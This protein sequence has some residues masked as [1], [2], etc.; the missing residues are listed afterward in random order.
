MVNSWI[1]TILSQVI[2]RK[3]PFSPLDIVED[4]AFLPKLIQLLLIDNELLF[5]HRCS[6]PPNSLLTILIYQ[7]LDLAFQIPTQSSSCPSLSVDLMSQDA[8]RIPD[9]LR[10]HRSLPVL[11]NH[12]F[13]F[14][15]D[16]STENKVV[17]KLE[18]NRRASEK[19]AHTLLHSNR[20]H[21]A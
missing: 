6:S 18:D 21:L 3:T 19:N 1:S 11:L 4:S 12:T 9:R 8:Q 16:R 13:H 17:N 7:V 14:S 5:T 10:G 20:S 15:F 2:Y